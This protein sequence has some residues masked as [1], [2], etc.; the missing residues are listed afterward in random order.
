MVIQH[1]EFTIKSELD[2]RLFDQ[3]KYK[4]AVRVGG[5]LEKLIP[6]A[7][8]PGAPAT[9]WSFAIQCHR[10]DRQLRDADRKLDKGVADRLTAEEV[11]QLSSYQTTLENREYRRNKFARA[12]IEST[13][14]GLIIPLVDRVLA[15]DT[16]VNSVMNIGARYA[17]VDH[18]LAS[19]HPHKQ[20]LAV[21]FNDD[22]A[23]M[24]AEFQ[25]DNIRFI[26]CYALDALEQGTVKPDV[27]IFSNT[28]MLIRNPELRRYCRAIYRASKYL[29]FNEPLFPFPGGFR[30][31]PHSLPVKRSVPMHLYPSADPRFVGELCLAHN[32]RAMVE[33]AGFK[34]LHYHVFKPPF[35]TLDMVQVVAVRD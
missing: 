24:N 15:R 1:F 9:R 27:S 23:E 13:F 31:D 12:K 6:K 22:L 33:E 35:T 20:F 34:L 18:L 25:R 8:M 10:H 28:A 11:R 19:K 3:L 26:S 7:A 30:L 21:D 2:Y 17:Y 32:Y 14:Q 4:A 5:R 29:V 16:A